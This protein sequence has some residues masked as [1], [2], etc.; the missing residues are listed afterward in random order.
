MEILLVLR[1][2]VL[3]PFCGLRG[4]SILRAPGF[5]FLFLKTNKLTRRAR[6][7]SLCLNTH[8]VH[9]KA[10]EGQTRASRLEALVI[11]ERWAVTLAQSSVTDSR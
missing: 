2:L 5:P 11:N 10:E 9:P 3:Q 7:D 6:S 8:N 1:E 4:T